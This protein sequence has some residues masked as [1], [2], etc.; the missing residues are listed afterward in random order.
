VRR[1]GGL[2][3]L[4]VDALQRQ[5]ENDVA[6]LA[7]VDELFSDLRGRLTDV[8]GAV[9]SLIVGEFDES[10]LRSARALHR[11]IADIEDLALDIGAGWSCCRGPS[12]NE[13]FELLELLLDLLLALLQLLDLAAQ[14]G[15]GFLGMKAWRRGERERRQCDE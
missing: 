13:L 10:E 9:R 8:P 5:V 7:G 2:E 12:L 6:E 11:I 4:A 15:I 14:V 3:R 1:F